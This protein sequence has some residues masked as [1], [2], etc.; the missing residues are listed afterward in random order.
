MALIGSI[1]I[2]MQVRTTQLSKGLK[3]A[4]NSLHAF[5]AKA[6]S[7]FGGVGKLVAGLATGLVAFEGAKLFGKAI[8]SASDLNEEINKSQVAFGEA[9]KIIEKDAARMQKSFG[10]PKKEFIAAASAIGLIGE[11]TGQSQTE[12]AQLGSKLTQLAADMSSFYNKDF[13]E[14]LESLQSGLVG[15]ARPLRPYGVLLNEASVD[16]Y[17]LAHGIKKVNG[18]YTDGQKIQARTALIFR[19]TAA[20]Q[21]DLARTADGTANRIREAW[22]RAGE[23]LT[24]VGSKIEPF[25]NR[26]LGGFNATLG[27][28]TDWFENNQQTINAW[29]VAVARYVGDA[30]E[31]AGMF[32]SNFQTQFQMMIDNNQESAS[33]FF[34]WI[35]GAWTAVWDSLGVVLRNWDQIFQS[36]M[37]RC[38][39]YILN[40]GESF[41]WL[42]KTIIAVDDYLLDQWINLFK[43]YYDIQITALKNIA[44]NFYDWSVGL[45]DQFFAGKP[46][47]LKITP[48]FEGFKSN[49]KAFEAPKMNLSA[50]DQDALDKIDKTIGDREVKMIADSEKR[51]KALEKILEPGKSAAKGILKKDLDKTKIEAKKE[52]KHETKQL[53]EA[54]L[55]GSEKARSTILEHRL[56]SPKKENEKIAKDQLAVQRQ[57]AKNT[58]KQAINF[59]NIGLADF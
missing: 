59:V 34:G 43:D 27:K 15:M 19:Q 50:I 44:K 11:A 22:G 33:S 45:A 8:T 58:S 24:E 40:L 20:A 49:A 55:A 26:L 16:N 51:K 13:A 52:T 39:H 38:G 54:M 21:G 35:S 30:F 46:L 41:I 42:E 37:I 56:R 28:I 5:E 31:T 12:A 2:G 14:T 18:E 25:A 1:V 4:S 32:V 3:Y 17:L 7:T 6:A 53:T 47:E 10:V 9:S 57:I 36:V 48:L 23:L 29:A